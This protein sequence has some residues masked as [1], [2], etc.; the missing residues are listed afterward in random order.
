MKQSG[1]EKIRDAF[2]SPW[3]KEQQQK[4]G[5]YPTWRTGQC[6]KMAPVRR[7]SSWTPALPLINNIET[8]VFQ[9]SHFF[10]RAHFFLLFQPA[11]YWKF[12]CLTNAS[13]GH[14]QPNSFSFSNHPLL[15]KMGKG[16]R[17]RIIPAPAAIKCCTRTAILMTTK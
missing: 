12:C 2:I 10:H 17:D 5:H 3:L 9:T 6:G 13:S 7:H 4:G 14:S 8:F 1:L 11:A 16:L 15:S